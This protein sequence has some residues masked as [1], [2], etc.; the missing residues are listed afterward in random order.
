M[1]HL[2]VHCTTGPEHPTRAALAFRVAR[3]ALEQGHSVEMFL[4][5]DAV[6]L[7]RAATLDS[8]VGVGTGPLAEHHA[9]VVQGGARIYASTFSS[10]ARGLNEQEASAAGVEL[11][12]P[13]RLIE[14]IM[15]ADRTVT[16]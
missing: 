16:Y 5:G 7:V 12:D 2:L 3:M 13:S 15:G 11:V 9:A 10:A 1:A 6:Q 4:A 8:V 14:L